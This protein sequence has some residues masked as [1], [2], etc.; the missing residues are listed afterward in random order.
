MVN[1]A[2]H[3]EIPD[4]PG[5]L[6]TLCQG[7]PES[8]AELIHDAFQWVV[9]N[10]QESSHA[11]KWLIEL[12]CG[13]AAILRDLGLDHRA[14]AAAIICA[15]ADDLQSAGQKLKDKFGAEVANL[16]TGAAQMSLMPALSS[17]SESL[18]DVSTENLRRMLIAMVNDVRVV[19]IKL[20]LHLQT[21]RISKSAP[22]DVRRRNANEALGVYAPLANRLGVWQLKWEMEDWSL[23]YLHTKSYHDI[24]AM[25]AERRV[26]REIYI[27]SF[28]SELSTALGEAG[29]KAEVQ[30]RP[31]H[32]YS[33]WRKMQHKD[34]DFE[35]IY[36]VR[37]VRILVDTVADCYSALG[38]V[39]T[40][41]HHIAGEF[42]DY[43]ATPKEN[44]YQSIH[45]A[46]VGPDGKVVEVQIRTREMHEHNELGVAAHWRYKENV[47]QDQ[48]VDNKVLWLRQLLE[49]REELPDASEMREHFRN[50]VFDQ[51]VYVFTP[52]GEVLDLP[53]ESTP[54]D[55]AYAVHT[56]VGHCCRGAKV[57]GKIVPLNYQLQNGERVEI[58]AVKKGGPSRD[59]L[60]PHLGY[61]HTSRA[62][63]RVARWF[64][65]EHYDENV[66]AGRAALDR[67]LH[68]LGVSDFSFEKLAHH[69]DYKKVEDFLAAIGC[70]DLKTSRAVSLLKNQLHTKPG[71]ELPATPTVQKRPSSARGVEVVGVGN[72]LTQMANCCRPLPGDDIVGYITRTRGVTIHRQDCANILRLQDGH[73]DRFVEV[74]WG[75]QPDV[76][77]PVDVSLKAYDRTGLLH[78]ITTVLSEANIGL[79]AVDL[80]TDKSDS[81]AFITLTLDIS[82]IEKLSQ[83]LGRIS[84][85]PNVVDIR[86]ITH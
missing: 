66:T 77:Y 85:V 13:S 5:V 83:V 36:D 38:V 70:G 68:R 60:S 78:D 56:E 72:L 33:I 53:K 47:K 73:W 45:S 54:V 40:C 3:I 25:L 65:E 55:F 21:L 43:I 62:R 17:K 28:V 81:L 51:R 18:G 6:D 49:W 7:L 37:A 11:L 63:A 76:T 32:I 52:R 29:I 15:G 26:D 1:T 59:W 22:D 12:G 41:W 14:L 20:A 46:V 2:S 57:N 67:E 58:L 75:D 48:G 24:A 64:K 61:L 79:R 86:R 42:D 84:R 71:P 10:T 35:N 8:E 39:H 69:L 31:K 50:D 82:D 23:R 16:A 80:K 34:T 27:D 4:Y 44:N 30:G 19:L 9:A 74:A